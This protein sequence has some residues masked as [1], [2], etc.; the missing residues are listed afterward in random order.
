MKRKFSLF[1]LMVVI[2]ACLTLGLGACRN[3]TSSSEDE[4]VNPRIILETDQ[5]EIALDVFAS[6]DYQAP[7]AGVYY[8]NLDRVDGVE[9]RAS[10]KDS[11]GSYIYENELDYVNKIKIPSFTGKYELIYSAEGCQNV[12][13]TIYVCER[14][15]MGVDFTLNNGTLTWDEVYGAIGYEVTVNGKDPVFVETASFTSDIFEKEGFYV[16]VT[17][18]GDNKT[19]IDSYMSSYENRIALKN[20]ELAAF[21]NACYELDVQPASPSNLNAP[22]EQ[23]QYLTEEECEGSTGGAL[24][25]LIKSGE[26]G[27]GLFR[28]YLQRTIDQNEDFDGMEIRFKLDSSS[29]IYQQDEGTTR[30]IL[31][32]PA[33]DERG[34]GR[35]TYLYQEHND[36]WQV[37]KIPKNAVDNF[38]TLNYLQFS[39]FNMTRSGGKGFLYLDYIRL[40]K[41]TIATPDNVAVESDKLTWSAVENAASYIVSVDKTDDEND[42]LHRALYTV[43]TSEVALATLGINLDATTLQYDIK[44][45]AVSAD[46]AKGSSV[47]SEMLSKRGALSEEELAPF[48]NALS[49]MDVTNTK[50]YSHMYWNGYDAVTGA[51]D[52]KAL[53]VALNANSTYGKVS[54]FTINLT[55]PLNL[56]TDY[57]CIIFRFQLMETNYTSLDTI[58]LQLLQKSIS[59]TNLIQTITVGE[60]IEYQVSMEDL[61]NYYETGD[62]KLSFKIMNSVENES[63]PTV[64]LK[65]AVDY[66]RYYHSIQAPENVRVENGMLKWDAV[67]GAGSYTVNVNGVAYYGIKETSYDISALTGAN[68]L[69]VLANS[70]NVELASSM[71]S[72]E[73]YYEV[74]DEDCLASFNHAGYATQVIAGNPN[75]TQSTLNV[76]IKEK[77]YNAVLGNDGALK[78]KLRAEKAVSGGKNHIFTVSL[79]EGLDLT[80]KKAVQIAF[81]V[82]SYSKSVDGTLADSLKFMVLHATSQDVGYT[83]GTVEV[84]TDVVVDSSYENFQTLRLTVEQLKALGYTDGMT[85]LTLSVWTNKDT[86]PNQGGT[87]VMAIDDIRY[88]QLLATPTNARIEGNFFKWDAVEDA[89]GYIVSV[90]GVETTVMETSFD[91]SSYEVAGT[92]K[93]KVRALPVNAD[94]WAPSEFT[95]EVVKFYL[96]DD[97]IVTFNDAIF[98]TMVVSGNPNTTNA[99][100]RSDALEAMKVDTAKG[101]GGA[102]YFKVRGDVSNWNKTPGYSH[103]VTINLPTGLDLTNNDGISIKFCV[104]GWSGTTTEESEATFLVL[105]ATTLDTDYRNG[106]PKGGASAMTVVKDSTVQNFQ[107]YTITS[108]QLKA[109]G[110]KDGTTYITISIRTNGDTLPGAGGRVQLWL[111][112]ICYYKEEE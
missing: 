86:G 54:Y 62:T 103:I 16:G 91:L 19:W 61:R 109:L 57:D 23:I 80:S 83:A 100:T 90:D 56:E 14:L 55:K 5:F 28:L 98:T 37:V 88:C 93:V 63:G 85:Y 38:D 111:D 64:Y 29:Y 78:L 97:E 68:V 67:D 65:M 107:T 2:F 77:D 96:K 76:D 42:Y 60:W 47:W 46:T 72:Q 73:T 17:A 43:K 44:V 106:T 51:E 110:Y 36:S 45:M 10:L 104:P 11:L 95:R 13:I 87:L 58:T 92:V 59:D 41:D 71:Y 33:A 79:A 6:M 1:A 69:K 75:L 8:E 84:S 21:D 52:G 81:C 32:R 20:G 34:V 7:Y 94:E 108:E 35:G 70:V 101:E 18:K 26:Y 105:H 12:I 39:L 50:T 82:G 102:L 99:S 24:R 4:R 53:L 9:I 49:E 30:F 15:E 22:P 74:L 3:T 27:T 25:L 40:Y 48:D 89:S 112:D 66:V 31:A